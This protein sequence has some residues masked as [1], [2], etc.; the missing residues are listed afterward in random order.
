MLCPNIVDTPQNLTK[1]LNLFFDKHDEIHRIVT[2]IYER[3]KID[4]LL[5]Q[6]RDKLL[7]DDSD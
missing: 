7:S 1:A 2:E 6:E 5:V 4:Y 3:C